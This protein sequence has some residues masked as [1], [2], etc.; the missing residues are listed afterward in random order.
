MLQ[1]THEYYSV[2]I[3]IFSG[4]NA[5]VQKIESLKTEVWKLDKNV[6]HG[7]NN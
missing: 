5:Y 6:N 3:T 2:S 7:I 4:I 1:Y